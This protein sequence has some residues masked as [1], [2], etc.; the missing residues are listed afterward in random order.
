MN[1]YR[2][3]VALDAENILIEALQSRAHL[4]HR[5]CV[6]AEMNELRGIRECEHGSSW[7]ETN[8]GVPAGQI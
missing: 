4:V 7:V 6:G 1:T 3:V 8:T 5:N 2:T